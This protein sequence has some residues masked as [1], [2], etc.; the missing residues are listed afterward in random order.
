MAKALLIAEKPDLMRQIQAIYKKRKSDIPYDIDFIAQRGHLF[1]LVTPDGY[2]EDR[3]HW[4]W[5]DLPFHPEEHGGWRYQINKEK[6]QGNFLTSKE[7]F[8]DIKKTY[9][10]GNYDFIINCGD[11]DQEGELLIRET[12]TELKVKEPVKRFWSNDLTEDAVVEALKNLKDDDNDPMLVNLTASAYVRQHSDYR[13]G[14]NL[15]ECASLKMKGRVALGRVKTPILAIVCQREEEIK[16]FK[17][18]T[19]YGVKANYTEGFTK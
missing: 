9:K 1:G 18:T 16:N 12:L 6:K 2:D 15:S 10:S 8:D 19:S 11:P 7:R 5:E 14:M 13:Y 4:K 17:P 3:K